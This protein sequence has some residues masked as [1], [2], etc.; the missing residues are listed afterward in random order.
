MAASKKKKFVNR[1]VRGARAFKGLLQSTQERVQNAL[2]NIDGGYGVTNLMYDTM[3][4]FTDTLDAVMP[5]A[6]SGVPVVHFIS[7][8]SVPT[9]KLPVALSEPC[10]AGLINKLEL[11]G[12][13]KSGATATPTLIQNSGTSGYE[14]LN[15]DTETVIASS[16]TDELDEVLVEIRSMPSNSGIYRA[17]LYAGHAKVLA[18]IVLVRV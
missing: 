16:D 13:G 2:G 3:E 15:P 18:E 8:G 17:V 10:Q 5:S 4:Q 7:N 12:L 14:I 6:P 9:E 11:M 1:G